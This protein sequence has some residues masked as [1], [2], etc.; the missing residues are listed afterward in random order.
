M[1]Q[2]KTNFITP[3]APKIIVKKLT[4]EVVAEAIQAYAK[5]DGYYLK[6]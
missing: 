4:K 2:E 1:E 5:N 6:L 3:E